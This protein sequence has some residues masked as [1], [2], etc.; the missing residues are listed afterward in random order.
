M[1]DSFGSMTFPVPIPGPNDS[2]HDSA[3]DCLGSYLTACLNDQLGPS[4]SAVNPG[5][6]F[7]E[8]FQTSEPGDSFNERDLPAMFLYRTA[9]FDEPVT[10]DWIEQTTDVTVTWVPQ[11]AVQFKKNL[12]ATS[13]NGFS[14]VVTRALH[15]G[16]S[17]AWIHPA[18]KSTSSKTRGSPLME[19]AGFFRVP[20]VTSAK[21]DYVTVEKGLDVATYPAFSLI[22]RIF[23]ITNWEDSF[24]SITMADRAPSKLDE[25][26][27]SGALQVSKLIPIPPIPTT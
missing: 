25:T 3:L 14:K 23:E 19:R 21:I 6:K 12:R 13:I 10:D 18:D 2:V 11:S 16:R 7:V 27:T 9:S 24:D 17:P 15:L 26:V 8:S 20:L 4:W 5:K 22:I 1:S